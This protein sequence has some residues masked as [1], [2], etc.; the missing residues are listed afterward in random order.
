VQFGAHAGAGIEHQAHG[1]RLVVGAEL[2]DGLRKAVVEEAEVLFFEPDYRP[3]RGITNRN[4]NQHQ[5]GVYAQV[6]ARRR[7]LFRSRPRAR[8]DGDLAQEGQRP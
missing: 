7:V 4:G 3:A 2:R 6:G 5:V 8:F 1:N